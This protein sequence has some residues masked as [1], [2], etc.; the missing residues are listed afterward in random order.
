[1]SDEGSAMP[2][3]ERALHRLQ[4]AIERDEAERSTDQTQPSAEAQAQAFDGL[5]LAVQ[6]RLNQGLG[7]VLAVVSGVPLAVLE[8]FAE[9][10]EIDAKN[11][12]ILEVLQ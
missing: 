6:W 12:A 7:D 8:R 4:V 3:Q 2:D 10:G 11:R 9:T 5:Q 1:M